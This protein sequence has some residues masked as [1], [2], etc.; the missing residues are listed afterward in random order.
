MY[1][2]QQSHDTPAGD[3]SQH[4]TDQLALL[5]PLENHHEQKATWGIPVLGHERADSPA[6]GLL[7]PLH[8]AQSLPVT[9][10][11]PTRKGPGWILRG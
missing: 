7:S 8:R 5:L 4:V 11:C 1:A 6:P 3:K 10:S 9:Y 2:E